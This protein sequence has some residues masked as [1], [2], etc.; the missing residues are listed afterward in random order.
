MRPAICSGA[1]VGHPPCTARTISTRAPSGSVRVGQT[2][3]RATSASTATA[4]PAVSG[5]ISQADE[6]VA[7]RGR[8]ARVVDRLA[9]D[10]DHAGTFPKRP[11]ANAGGDPRRVA[12]EPVGDEVGGDRREQDPVAVMAGR[13]VQA[14]ELLRRAEHRRVVGRRR[15]QPR[16]HLLDDQLVHA[17]HDLARV[18]QQLVEAA[19]GDRRV[20]AALLHRRAE[21]VAPVAARDEVAALEAHDALEQA[22]TGGIAQAQDLA[23]DRA[24]RDARQ[25]LDRAAPRAGGR[26]DVTRAH[27]LAAGQ[28]DAGHATGALLEALHARAGAQRHA[29]APRGLGEREHERAR[30]GRVVAGHVEREAHGGRQRRLQAPGGARQQAPDVEAELEAHGE[31]AVERL[32]LVAVARDDERAAAPEPRDRR[33]RRRRAARRTAATRAALRRPS[34]RS[35]SSPASASVTGASMPAATCEAPAPSSPRSS[36]Q[37][38]WPRCAARQATASPM[39]PP[40]MTATSVVAVGSCGMTPR[41]AGMIRISC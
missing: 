1:D 8:L 21:H 32:R 34:C 38:L 22:G 12:V 5:S 23:L 39:T 7:D 41:F 2:P 40:P 9:V 27:D 29:G 36:T 14:G 6:D 20:E 19:G 4:M 18:A 26:H 13:P 35:A 28:A 10:V 30:V 3:R 16:G 33:P 11:A 25:A 37:T 31:L 15:A 17:G 24:Q